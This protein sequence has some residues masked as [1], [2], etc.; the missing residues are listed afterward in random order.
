[1]NLSPWAARIIAW[2]LLANICW[3]LIAFV[4]SP[5]IAQISRDRDT[6]SISRDLLARYQRLQM[7]MPAIQ[8][9]LDELRKR[10]ET[11]RYFLTSASPAL[12]AAELQNTLREL[13]SRSGS[14]MKSSKSA[15]T[16]TEN[17]FDSVG[18]DLELTASTPELAAFLRS[19]AQAEPIILIERLLAQVPETGTPPLAIDGQPAISVSLRLVSYSRRAQEGVKS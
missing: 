16:L 15:R 18:V 9:Q 3:A 17:G 10:K 19:V 12:A 13:V 2:G 5:L 8:A 14:T 1:M 6:I 7:D 4:A 11:S